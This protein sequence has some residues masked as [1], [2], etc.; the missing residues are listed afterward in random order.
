MADFEDSTSPTWLN[1]LD[2]QAN[3]LAANKRTI[4]F[5]DERSGKAYKLSPTPATLLVRYAY[6]LLTI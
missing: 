5:A 3:L 1:L 2:G 6:S 4:D